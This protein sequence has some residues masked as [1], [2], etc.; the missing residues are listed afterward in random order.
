MFNEYPDIVS[1]DDLR[2]M[3]NIGKSSAYSLLQNNQIPY[4]RF[5][6]KYIIPKTAVIGFI[7]K[8][9]YNSGQIINGRFQSVTEGA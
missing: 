7:E 8:T 6:R 5:G 1:V 4:V 3:L 2:Q 9:C